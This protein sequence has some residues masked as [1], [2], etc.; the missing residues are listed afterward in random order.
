MKINNIR[1]VLYTV[2]KILGDVN[3]VKKGKVGKR[4][5]RRVAGKGTGKMLQKLFK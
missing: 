3:A 4:I 1:K 2:S 5:G